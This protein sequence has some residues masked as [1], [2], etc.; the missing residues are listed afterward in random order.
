MASDAAGNVYVAG[1]ASSGTSLW[2]TVSLTIPA[3]LVNSMVV[4]KYDRSGE[5]QWARTI[6][7]APNPS[8]FVAAASNAGGGLYAVGLL[9]GT[10][11]YAFAPEVT[12]NAPS[13]TVSVLVKYQE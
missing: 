1:S 13:S 5:V 4:A 7:D 6:P 12:V 11:S 8:K 9:Y 2:G 3:N 10:G